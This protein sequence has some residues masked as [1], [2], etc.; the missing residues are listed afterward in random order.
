M[1]FTFKMIDGIKT[2]KIIKRISETEKREME[3][4]KRHEMLRDR[5]FTDHENS[6]RKARESSLKA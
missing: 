1:N 5:V 6:S 2:K 3:E 4:R